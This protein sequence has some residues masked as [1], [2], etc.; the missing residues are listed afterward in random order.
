MKPWQP[1]L[2][3]LQ[4]EQQKPT[5]ILLLSA[6]LLLCW[7]YF[8]TPAS[9]ASLL[10]ETGSA[11][12]AAS[13]GAV[14]HFASCLILLGVL[15]AL[16]VKFF[17]GERLRD[18]GVG[19]GFPQRVFRATLIFGPV[20]ALA[21]YLSA[22]D[23]GLR[24]KFPINPHAGHS[25]AVFALHAATYLAYYAGWEFY[26]RGFLLF[27]LRGSVGDANAVLIQVLASSLLH[28]GSPPA[29]TFGAILG[30]LL[31]GMQALCTRS[32]IPGLIQHFLLGISLDLALCFP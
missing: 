18:Y 5:I 1:I 12:Q 16:L 9:F 29:E 20:F 19:G 15:P 11:E 27:G 2:A 14:G 31:W 28:I 7:K 4:G 30:G 26:F 22:T 17:V 13:A 32:L 3:A 24:E 10:A 25:A 23:P 8:C 6:P 21:G